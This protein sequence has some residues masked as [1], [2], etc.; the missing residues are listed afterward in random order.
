[1]STIAAVVRTFPA[2]WATAPIYKKGAVLPNGKKACGKSPLGKAH[3]THLSPQ[4]SLLYLEREPET[5]QAVG[6]F[7]GARSSGL[8]ILD[9]DANLAAL[10][11]KHGEDLARAPKITSTKENAAKFLF[12]VPKEFWASVSDVSLA[13][14][15]QGFEVLW[16]RQA[17]L[18]G[19]YAGGGSYTFQGDPRAVPAAPEWLLA[20]MQESFQVKNSRGAERGGFTRSAYGGRSKEERMA[21]ARSCLAVIPPQGRGSEDFWWRIGAMVNSELPGEEGLEI[22]REWSQRDDEYSDAWEDGDPCA[23]RWAA[24]FKKNGGLTFGSLVQQADQHDPGRT[25][26]QRNG[27]SRVVEEVEATPVRYRQDYISGAELLERSISLEESI[28]DPALLDQAKHLLALEAGRREGA[29][30]IDRLIDSHLSY[31]RSGG[32]KPVDVSQLDDS[33]FD[34]LI[35]GLL[36]KPWLLLVH[37]DGGTGKTAMAMTMAKH[38]VQGKQFEVHGKMFDVPKGKVLWLNGDQSERITRRQL[39]L[40][41]VESGVDV[42]GEWDMAWYRRFCSFQQAKEYDLIVIDSLDGCNDSNPYEENRREY[43]LPLKRLARRNGID[44]PATSIVV[45]HH[46]NRNGGFRGTSAIRAAVDETWNMQRMDMK[47][48]AELGLPENT[49]LI[50]VEK[51]RDTREGQQMTFTLQPDFTYRIGSLTAARG[52]GAND[53]LLDVLDLLTEAPEPLCVADV[54]AHDLLGGEHRRRAIRYALQRLEAQ[55]L[56]VRCAPPAGAVFTGRP[57]AYYCAPASNAPVP[58]S[59]RPLTRGVCA[60]VVVKNQNPCAGT[61]SIDKAVC[62]K[63]GF[64]KRSGT[65]TEPEGPFDNQDLLTNLL[66]KDFPC[67]GTDLSF[68]ANS[69]VPRVD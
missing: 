45:I 53:Y 42:V 26:F 69:H 64:V 67:A 10:E 57:P 62:Q 47:K 37:A 60:E 23:D 15:G 48:L 34:Y 27:L 41:G 16:G 25:R 13:A 31:K 2:D 14:S 5:F 3:H 68:D 33:D 9:V 30:A 29:I 49:R 17:V 55:K 40:I 44:F 58:F 50:S 11:G 24:G 52:L 6:V 21:I 20:L 35:P 54:V 51:S 38:V 46:N 18:C 19:A 22:W 63:V 39:N 36:P 59:K 43:A 4:Q 1:M 12:A 8:V 7:S 56:I 61:D 28:D 32:G 66:S 65:G